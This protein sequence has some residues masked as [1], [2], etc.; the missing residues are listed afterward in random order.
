MLG[1][2]GEVCGGEGQEKW[3]GSRDWR[4]VVKSGV[5]FCARLTSKVLYGGR[6][7]NNMKMVKMG[8]NPPLLTSLAGMF[9]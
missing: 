3:R 2:G 7:T 1:G 9:I 4:V 5:G 6:H 8:T